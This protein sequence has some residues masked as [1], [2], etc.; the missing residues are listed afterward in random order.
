MITTTTNVNN[1]DS[2]DYYIGAIKHKQSDSAK[3]SSMTASVMGSNSCKDCTDEGKAWAGAFKMLILGYGDNFASE[4]YTAEKAKGLYDVA[5]TIVN[6]VVKV[7]TG[8][9]LSYGD[10]KMGAG[11]T[12]GGYGEG[13]RI[14]MGDGG[15]IVGS[16]TEQTTT[17]TATTAEGNSSAAISPGVS[18]ESSEEDNEEDNDLEVSN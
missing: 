12:G 14:D 7:S 5:E 10:F 4:A 11:S 8:G 16:F 2:H 13:L 1:S 3:L 18:E 6:G 9:I 17:T 15:S